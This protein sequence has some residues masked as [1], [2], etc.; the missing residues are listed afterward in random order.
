MPFSVWAGRALVHPELG[1]SVIPIQSKGGRLL[2]APG[3]EKMTTSLHLIRDIHIE[4]S[5]QFKC[6]S[7]FY[8]SGQSRPFW[9]ALKLL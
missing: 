2:I 7:Y 6:N 4:C 1:S 8:V 3:F 5:K 9:A